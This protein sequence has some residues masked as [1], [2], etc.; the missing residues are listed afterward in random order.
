VSV[1]RYE[2]NFGKEDISL[3]DKT[4]ELDIRDVRTVE[5]S[6]GIGSSG[7]LE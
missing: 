4:V 6:S 2:N 7:L 1:D 5:V 3:D